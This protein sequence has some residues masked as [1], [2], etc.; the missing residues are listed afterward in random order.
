MEP[1]GFLLPIYDDHG[2]RQMDDRRPVCRYTTSWPG[3]G[4]INSTRRM[5]FPL[6]AHTHPHGPPSGRNSALSMP[7]LTTPGLF[8][9]LIFEAQGLGRHSLELH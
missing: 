7:R 6:L 2:P 8:L 5:N 4:S 3:N 1:L 9:R